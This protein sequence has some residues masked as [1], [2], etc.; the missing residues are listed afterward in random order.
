[1][2]LNMQTEKQD[3]PYGNPGMEKMRLRLAAEGY[4]SMENSDSSDLPGMGWSN[5]KQLQIGRNWDL[6]VLHN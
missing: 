3:V 2:S 1:M 6:W 5:G 4:N